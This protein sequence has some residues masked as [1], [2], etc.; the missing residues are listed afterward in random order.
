MKLSQ[1]ALSLILSAIMIQSVMTATAVS[2]SA[3]EETVPYQAV[4]EI[5]TGSEDAEDPEIPDDPVISPDEQQ[6]KDWSYAEVNDIAVILRYSGTETDVE[7]PAQIDGKPVVAIGMG[8]FKGNTTMQS[9][10]IPDSVMSIGIGAFRNCTALSDISGGNLV[11]RIGS[12]AFEGCTSLTELPLMYVL[13]YVGA[14][15]FRNCSQLNGA[16]L[17]GVKKINPYTFAGCENMSYITSVDTVKVSEFAFL[18]CK[19]LRDATII[20]GENVEEVMTID[21][22]AFG[23]CTAL[24]N[25]SLHW[26]DRIK[27]KASAFF[28]CKS[29]ENVYY[30]GTAERWKSNV[31]VAK[32]G[33]FYFN[34]AEIHFGNMNYAELDT[35]E[36]Q[37]NTGETL[38]LTYHSAPYKGQESEV[39][40]VRWESTNP[41]VAEVD[42]NG[43]VTAKSAGFTVINL[44]SSS[45][46]YADND[47]LCTVIVKQAP[48][49]V[50]IN[51]TAVNVG[52][53]QVYNLNAAVT[54]SDAPQSIKWSSSD[55]SI[56]SVDENGAVTAK[57][58]GTAVITAEA[59]NGITA[60]CKVNVK[61]APESIT[62]DKETL[63]LNVNSNYTFKKILSA[64]SATSFKW[65]S[66]DPDVVRVYSTGKIVA[67]KSGTSVI[68]VTTHNGLTASC[69]VT[70]K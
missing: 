31:K 40:I 58:T 51:K 18:N 47:S 35:K 1:K 70:V 60:T 7:I 42:E 64:N 11:V 37:M 16:M 8:A 5:F 20:A 21:P 28:N 25:V 41:D 30:A 61:K 17:Y 62:L 44:V 63:T 32:T 68:T 43:N 29:I 69:T 66:S 34:K 57:K 33:N 55:D 49:N 54:P 4:T 26:A 50:E 15:A 2:V 3:E 23:N 38:Q 19:N 24:S 65:T 59:E 12:R 46:G 6:F 48:E 53:G 67:Q 13:K 14:A 36:A 22:M 39:N 56:A 9:V 45:D 27:V 10:V 52:V